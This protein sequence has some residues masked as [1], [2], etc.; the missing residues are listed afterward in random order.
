[1]SLFADRSYNRVMVFI[2]YRNLMSKYNEGDLLADIFRLTQILVGNRDLAGAYIYDGKKSGEDR[3]KED[4]DELNK[5]RSIGFR[6]ITR[7]AVVWRGDH[8]EQKEV[9]VS[10]AVDMLEHALLNHYDVAILVSGDRDYIPVIQR[11]QASGKRVEVASYE[12]FISSDNE[13]ILTADVYH[14]LKDI[15]FLSLSSPPLDGGVSY[16]DE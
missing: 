10:L 8:Y 1:M 7:E 6:L 5:L 15:P 4:Q 12:D 13:L 16:H 9:D 14:K 3:K 11:V 2:D